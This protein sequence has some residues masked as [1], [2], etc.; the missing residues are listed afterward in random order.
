MANRIP[1]TDN[2]SWVIDRIDASE[3]CASRRALRRAR[4]TRRLNRTNTGVTASDIAVSSGESTSIATT[5]EIS[6]TTL[7]TTDDA[8][9]VIVVCTP[10][11]SLSSLDWTSPLRVAV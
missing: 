7:L 2:V 9:E 8:V 3:A 5:D 6:V 11:T 10:P 1:D 4:P